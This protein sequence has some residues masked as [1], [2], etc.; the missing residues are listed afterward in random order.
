MKERYKERNR[1]ERHIKTSTTLSLTKDKEKAT[2]QAYLKVTKHK[3]L[4]HGCETPLAL[5]T[6]TA[7][8]GRGM[9]CPLASV[10]GGGFSPAGVKPITSQNSMESRTERRWL[11]QAPPKAAP[12]SALPAPRPVTVPTRAMWMPWPAPSVAS[13]TSVGVGLLPALRDDS[14]RS[15]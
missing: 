10:K 8:L 9:L 2:M 1:K 15:F 12:T 14:G 5:H 13:H 6:Q 11:K 7:R 3:A 4:I